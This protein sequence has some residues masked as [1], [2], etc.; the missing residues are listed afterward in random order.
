VIRR[1]S[2]AIVRQRPIDPRAREIK[3]SLEAGEREKGPR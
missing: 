3:R 2:M 1:E